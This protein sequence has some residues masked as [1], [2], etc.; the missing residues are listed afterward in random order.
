[1]KKKAKL[2]MLDD[3]ER[4]LFKATAYRQG[5]TVA[6]WMR[7][8]LIRN[9]HAEIARV[10]QP[11]PAPALTQSTPISTPYDQGTPISTPASSTPQADVDE[12]TWTD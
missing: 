5:L 12:D 4:Q 3:N 8:T 9:A 10:L 7:S 2:I 11:T 1:M 6:G